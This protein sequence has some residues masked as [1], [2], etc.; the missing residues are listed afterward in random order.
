[1]GVSVPESTV[2]RPSSDGSEPVCKECGHVRSAHS[3]EMPYECM[4]GEMCDCEGFTY[5][6]RATHD[7]R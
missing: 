7:Q 5:V 1:M 6:V 4:D 3:E 2:K